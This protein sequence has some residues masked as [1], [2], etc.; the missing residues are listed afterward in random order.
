MLVRGGPPPMA[1][2]HVM[3]GGGGTDGHT[4]HWRLGEAEIR[5]GGVSGEGWMPGV[6]GAN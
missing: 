6:L 1:H 5:I 3:V 4:V 2:S